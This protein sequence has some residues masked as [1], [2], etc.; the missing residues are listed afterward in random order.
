MPSYTPPA[1]S[2]PP[3][4]APAVVPRVLP[5]NANQFTNIVLQVQTALYAY[6]YYAGALT[7]I[8]DPTTKAALSQMQSQ[9]GLPVTGTITPD[10]L[11]ALSITAQ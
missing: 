10:V 9:Y 8:V 4:A 11:D 5:G 2:P 6:G 3:V 7:G 1:Y